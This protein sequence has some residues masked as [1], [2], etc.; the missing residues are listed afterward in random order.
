MSYSSYISASVTYDSVLA[1]NLN[2]FS[3]QDY[4]ADAASDWLFSDG[5]RQ[6]TPANSHFNR[7]MVDTDASGNITAWEYDLYS[8]P[9]FSYPEVH[10]T[11][12][13]PGTQGIVCVNLA[14][15]IPYATA[16]FLYGPGVD[17]IWTPTIVPEPGALSLVACA[18]MAAAL[19]R[20]HGQ[21]G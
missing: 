12:S 9:G 15:T 11:S 20:K 7:A 13:S 3:S 16:I 14:E 10:L 19:L 5:I 18:G 8:N 21:T 6:W 1:P 2:H 17:T 4:V